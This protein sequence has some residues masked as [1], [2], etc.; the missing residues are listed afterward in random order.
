MKLA[1]INSYNCDESEQFKYLKSCGFDGCDFIMNKYFA[2]SGIYGDIDEVTEDEIRERFT[3]LKKLA[4]EAD[5]KIYQVHASFGGQMRKYPGGEEEVIKRVTASIQAAH[6]LGA[7]H[8]VVHPYINMDRKYDKNEELSIQQAIDLYKKF[9]PAL[10]KYDV[11]CCIENMF[12]SDTVHR[13]I[14][15]TIISRAKE[16][17]RVC[18]ECGDRFRICL[19]V[20]HAVLTED[21]PA[22][23][24]R[25][26]GKRLVC[27]HTHDNDGIN[28]LHTIPFCAQG[29]PPKIEPMRIDWTE[30]M[31]AL[32]EVGYEGVLSFEIGA[33]G[34]WALKPAGLRYLAA[35]G[36][37]LSDIF[38]NYEVEQK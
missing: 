29:K 36:R 13:H 11:Y 19:D 18:D 38:E 15:P 33:P 25:I 20:G 3:W 7:K 34:P 17:V 28:D 2:P 31:H 27:L 22:E 9:I 8:V 16:I 1:V 26:C 6:Y 4:D 21:D 10:E 5:F 14:C 30:F 35:V 12:H 32:K 24:V 37:H 23:Y